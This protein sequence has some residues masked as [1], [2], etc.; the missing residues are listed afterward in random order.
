[1]PDRP[2]PLDVDSRAVRDVIR[3]RLSELGASGSWACT[4]CT[5]T[6]PV[7]ASFGVTFGSA[8]EPLMFVVC[9]ECAER[10]AVP[11]SV[12]VDLDRLGGDREHPAGTEADPVVDAVLQ[13]AG[14][15]RRMRTSTT[16]EPIRMRAA[17]LR[18][19]ARDTGTT[20][21]DLVSHLEQRGVARTA[22][23]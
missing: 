1:M 3:L 12:T 23:A 9:P 2:F 10:Y 15:I 6:F 7:E 16:D 14:T 5:C 22:A 4:R 13:E 19:I 17:D 18:R 21:G 8:G 20:P 11:R